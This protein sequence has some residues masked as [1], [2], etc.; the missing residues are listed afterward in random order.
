M[1]LSNDHQRAGVVASFQRAA[2][3]QPTP[4]CRPLLPALLRSMPLHNNHVLPTIPRN[5][6]HKCDGVTLAE[7]EEKLLPF[8]QVGGRMAEVL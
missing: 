6:L 8:S 5:A 4:P 7:M 2:E 3:P 1:L